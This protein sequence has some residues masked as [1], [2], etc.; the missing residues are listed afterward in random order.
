MT[1]RISELTELSA[2]TGSDYAEVSED[3]GA[4]GYDS[5]KW[6]PGT[7]ANQDKDKFVQSALSTDPDDPADGDAIQWVSDG[8]Q[9]GDAGDVMMKIN[10]GGTVKTV[11]LVD[12]SA[13]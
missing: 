13:A 1:K 5:K 4:G 12:Y 9:S 6:A 2:I 3:D 7:A 11:T 10:V 8:T